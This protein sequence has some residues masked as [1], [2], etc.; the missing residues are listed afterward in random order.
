MPATWTMAP[1][2]AIAPLDPRVAAAWRLEPDSLRPLGTGLIN[3]TFLARERSG[4]LRV[5]QQVNPVFPP[6]VNEDIDAVTAHLAA[7]GL[8]TPRL[9]RTV[10]G[11]LC[12]A[13]PAGAWRVLTR[14]PGRVLDAVERPAQAREAGRLLAAFH[15]ALDDLEHE[16]RH[17]RPP[18]HEPA[19]HLAA[20]ER[21]VDAHRRHRLHDDA[22]A[23]A[24]DIFLAM[25]A[26]PPLPATP[27]RVVHGDPKISNLVFA[28][29]GDHAVC[30]LDLDTVGRMA[31][32][33]ELG[34]AF[35]S[36][37]NVASED[38]PRGHFSATLFEA[39]ATGY[40]AVAGPWLQPAEAAAAVNATATIQVELAARFCADALNESYFGWNPHLFGSRGDHNLARARGQLAVHRSLVGEYA[41]LEDIAGRVLGPA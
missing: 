21:A 9:V 41:R 37:C 16:F 36:W 3:R 4:E 12:I 5:L 18:V 26:L 29:H 19:R 15:R 17:V 11:A 24:E 7:C 10:D 34:D 39:A 1:V 28:P 6:A 35:R 22:A 8:P 30:M 31:L 40:G 33:F 23:L 25:D 14:M 2:N 27:A 38:D 20:L 13:D 32:P